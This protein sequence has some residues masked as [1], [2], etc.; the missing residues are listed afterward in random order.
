[1]GHC[2][3]E[4]VCDTLHLFS[5]GSEREDE[6]HWRKRRSLCTDT[7]QKVWDACRH[8]VEALDSMDSPPTRE[9]IGCLEANFTVEDIIE[10]KADIDRYAKY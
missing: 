4:Q 6:V 10:A 8:R 1:M 5:N 7:F 9:L 2:L 3:G